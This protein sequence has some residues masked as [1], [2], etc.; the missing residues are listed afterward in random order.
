[1]PA[2]WS[3]FLDGLAAFC[4]RKRCP[5]DVSSASPPGYPSR[6]PVINGNPA[7]AIVFQSNPATVVISGPT[8]ILIRYP[9][10]ADIGISPVA[11]RIWPPIR[12]CRGIRLPDVAVVSHFVPVTTVQ[13]VVKKVD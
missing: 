9:R 2:D 1:M 11:V 13:I 8:E 5:P 10:P 12:V 7:P 6:S 4:W 3:A